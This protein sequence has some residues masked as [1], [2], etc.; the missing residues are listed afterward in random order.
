MKSF[1][2]SYIIIIV[3]IILK[4]KTKD[5][6]SILI[7][8][9]LFF[10]FILNATSVCSLQVNEIA[11]DSIFQTDGEEPII[12]SNKRSRSVFKLNYSL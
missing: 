11:S 9:F 2:Y 10:I 3:I 6:P 1:K 12:L 7:P 4:I 8:R 5:S